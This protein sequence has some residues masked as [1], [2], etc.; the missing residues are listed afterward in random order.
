MITILCSGS[1]GDIQPYV[2]LAQQLKKLGREVRITAG[3][4]FAPFVERYGIEVFPLSADLETADV[5][6]RML[7]DAGSSD[8]PLKMLLTFNKMKR[9]TFHMTDEMY[10][11]CEGSELVVYHPGCAVGYFAG[12]RLGIPAALASPFPLHRTR[13]YPA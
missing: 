8:N 1:R 6:P 12:Q 5:D 11:A 4:G 2:A 13:A 3:A 10:R 7:K 9:Y